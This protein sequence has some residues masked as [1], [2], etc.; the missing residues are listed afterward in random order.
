MVFDLLSSHPSSQAGGVAQSTQKAGVS[1]DISECSLS[2]VKAPEGSVLESVCEWN[3]P[4]L[5]KHVQDHPSVFAALQA[6]VLDSCPE[7]TT[8]QLGTAQDVPQES[9]TTTSVQTSSAQVI[10]EE[11][12]PA[13][14]F[15]LKSCKVN[16]MRLPDGQSE[17]AESPRAKRTPRRTK[18]KK[19]YYTESPLH[20]NTSEDEAWSPSLIDAKKGVACKGSGRPRG[21]SSQESTSLDSDEDVFEETSSKKR[22]RPLKKKPRQIQA[23]E[24]KPEAKKK[25]RKKANKAEKKYN[26]DVLYVSS[27]KKNQ[28]KEPKVTRG[29]KRR[30]YTAAVMMGEQSPERKSA[31]KK[32]SSTADCRRSPR[33]RSRSNFAELAAIEGS[34]PDDSVVSGA[35]EKLTE[36][37]SAMA[38]PE[39][40]S[41]RPKAEQEEDSKDAEAATEAAS[42][43]SRSLIESGDSGQA[44]SPPSNEEQ[45]SIN[46][47]GCAEKEQVV[48]IIIEPTSVQEISDEKQNSKPDPVV[49]GS[50]DNDLITGESPS[51]CY[52]SRH[53]TPRCSAQP[54]Q[55]TAPEVLS[56]KTLQAASVSPF[57]IPSR[58]LPPRL[59]ITPVNSLPSYQPLKV[60]SSKVTAKGARTSTD[61]EEL[62]QANDSA[63][64]DGHTL[65]SQAI[66]ANDFQVESFYSLFASPLCD[67]IIS[68]TRFS[69][70]KLILFTLCDSSSLAISNS[71]ISHLANTIHNL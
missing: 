23:A 54:A 68:C 21:G 11:T 61:E 2:P 69:A 51:A 65:L 35:V 43:G 60:S 9:G 70:L 12:S 19:Q 53:S 56:C 39:V 57:V 42:D 71:I 55:S 31:P 37:D 22:H 66:R 44:R 40:K 25:P 7:G 41:E 3:T 29:T 49:I 1:V 62:S 17:G 64:S 38:A 20:G 46:E 15:P 8:S 63:G 36:A 30:L 34:K 24:E 32:T 47:P 50:T 26:V 58:V 13:E 16:L 45:T 27:A 33:L 10:T 59:T 67:R 5:V 14:N 18:Q 48:N 52:L 28:P 6:A 4:S